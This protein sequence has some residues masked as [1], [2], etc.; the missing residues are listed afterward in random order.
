M[1]RWPE[2]GAAA[3]YGRRHRDLSVGLHFDMAEWVYEGDEWR[4]VYEVVAADDTDAVCEELERQLTAFRE[5][6]GEDPTHLDSHQHVHRKEP[7]RSVLAAS[8]AEM[9]IPLRDVTPDV[10][11]RGDFYGQSATGDPYPEGITAAALVRLIEGLPPGVSEMGCHPG[12]A[13]DTWSSYC[14]ERA[15]EVRALCD[16]QVKEAIENE[17]VILG[18]YRGVL[19]HG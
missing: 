15:A 3:A 19:S 2:S 11:Y 5:L 17:D 18:S 1:V 4:A 14:D 9:G 10:A 7:V 8:A 16:L 12:E 13:G 6:V